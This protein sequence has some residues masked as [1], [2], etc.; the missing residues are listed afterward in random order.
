MAVFYNQATLRYT[1]GSINSNIISG[2]VL[3]PVTVSKTAV[4][5]SYAPGGTVTYVVSVANSGPVPVTGV[6]VSDDLGGYE[7]C[8]CTVYPLEYVE[9]SL[10]YYVD[11]LRQPTPAVTAGPPLTVRGL[12]VPAGDS[13]MLI[14]EA[15]V[16]CYAPLGDCAAIENTVTVTGT[17]GCFTGPLTACARV[18]MEMGPA[19]SIAKSVC[20]QVVTGCGEVTYTFVIQ[21]AG[22]CT[23]GD[24]GLAV[25]DTFDPVLRE[26]VVT[27]DGETLPVSAYTYDVRTGAFATAPGTLR[28]PAATFGQDRDGCWAVNPGVTVLTVT[29]VM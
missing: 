19:L 25:T 6:T 17:G 8:G 13:V 22:G 18:P 15:R 1:G 2:E 14:Y 9:G 7:A 20:P 16:T 28:V 3:E 10:L 29:G 24:M 21:N 12:T 26:L 4:S 5:A 27:L 11:G 23:G